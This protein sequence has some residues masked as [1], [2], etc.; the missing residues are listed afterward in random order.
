MG[1]DGT[2]RR[3]EIFYMEP[4]TLWSFFIAHLE[5]N[6]NTRYINVSKTCLVPSVRLFKVLLRIPN[7]LFRL[8][9]NL[10]QTQGFTAA[11]PTS[12]EERD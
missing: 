1:Y 12:P 5:N 7:T 8:I 6:N 3:L 9:A 11:F 2:R 4:G 10:L